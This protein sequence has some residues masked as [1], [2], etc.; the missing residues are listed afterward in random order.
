VVIKLVSAAITHK[1]DVG[2]V[3]LGLNTEKEVKQ[4]YNDIKDK[5]AKQGRDKDME[6]VIVQKMIEGGIEAIVGVTQDPSFGPLIMFGSG[7]I[8]AELIKDVAFR[9]HPLTDLDADELIRSVKLVS[10]YEGYRGSPPAD[11]AAVQ[12]LLLRLSIMVED[13]PQVA[14]IDFNPV[15]ALPQGEGYRI[16]DARILIR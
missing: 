11:I 14:E 16:L 8:Y 15:K 12:E 7:G 5:L 6:G 13:L 2:G 10:L 4:A 1:T 9:L 3:V